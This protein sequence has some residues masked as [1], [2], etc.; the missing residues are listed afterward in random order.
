MLN[1]SPDSF[2]PGSR[3]A[4]VDEV[5]RLAD[6]FIA[7]GA[8]MLDIGAESSQPRSRPTAVDVELERLLPAVREVCRRFTIPVSVDTY[9]PDVAERVLDAGAV[10]INDITGLQGDAGM[11]GVIAC[12]RAGVIAMHMLG[13]PETMQDN[14]C[15]VDPMEDILIFL[16]R[17]LE[18]AERAGIGAE[19]IAIDPGIGFGKTRAH[20]LTILAALERLHQTLDKP[21]MLGASRKSFIGEGL[22]LPVDERLEGSLAAAVLGLAK[23]AR[24]FR[25]H[26]VQATVRALTLAQSILAS[27]STKSA[28]GKII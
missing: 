1:L 14:P 9:K 11:A 17:S 10:C 28:G 22:G 21:V 2:Y 7:E 23:G 20:N 3:C 18:I 27:A 25:V 6:R 26:D 13:T 16:R 4:G 19:R 24:L 5:L 15:Y 8:R 12:K